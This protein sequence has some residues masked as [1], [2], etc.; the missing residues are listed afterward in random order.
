MGRSVGKLFFLTSQIPYPL[1]LIV[2]SP[3]IGNLTKY[4][5]NAISIVCV[6][7]L[8]AYFKTIYK[9]K[10]KLKINSTFYIGQFSL[11]VCNEI[12]KIILD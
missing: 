10:K 12:K 7:S 6:F 8:I 11:T 5:N 3:N 9:T 1:N 2:N 4:T